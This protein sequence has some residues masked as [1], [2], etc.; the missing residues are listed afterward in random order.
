MGWFGA[1]FAFPDEYIDLM[2]LEERAQK[3]A[4]LESHQ[5]ILKNQSFTK[6]VRPGHRMEVPLCGPKSCI[7]DNW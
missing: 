1:K 3:S 2:D 4:F 7:N 6:G 5:L